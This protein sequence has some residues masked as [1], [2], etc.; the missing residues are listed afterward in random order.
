MSDLARVE[1]V[2]VF[3]VDTRCEE[4]VWK[5]FHVLESWQG[6]RLRCDSR[7]I[8]FIQVQ[9]KHHTGQRINELENGPSSYQLKK[10]FFGSN[11]V[12]FDVVKDLV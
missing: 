11:R 6:R 7:S 8:Q 3:V 1:D 10:Q 4:T 5:E 12:G 9:Q 2:D